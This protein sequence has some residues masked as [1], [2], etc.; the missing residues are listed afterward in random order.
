MQHNIPYPDIEGSTVV[1][2]HNTHELVSLTG[3]KDNKKNSFHR[4]FQSFRQPGSAIKHLLVYGPYIDRNNAAIDEQIDS[5]AFCK[6]GYC[7]RNYGNGNYGNV[8]L[9]TAF[10]KS[11]NTSAV[12]IFD[13][14]G[15]N[16][17]FAYLEKFKFTK[18][19]KDDYQLPAAIGGFTYGM[20]PIEITNAY[21]SFNNGS[22]QTARAIRKI[23]DS[24]GKTL[25]QWKEHPI[26]IWNSNTVVKMKT[27]LHAVIKEGTA[28]KADYI[29]SSN[30][31]GK[32]GT[33]NDYKDLWMIGY[34]DQY[35]TG[36][37]IGK[38]HPENIE[39][40]GSPHLFI[41]RN[42]MQF[43]ANKPYQK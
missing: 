26:Q 43:T 35:T 23:T 8:K 41:W 34:N 9:K 3:A 22:Y 18:L 42:I 4:G 37:W 24:S 19:M 30:I 36:V 17:S 5:S 12:R 28:K 25:Y 1:I 6:N 40:S 2:Q 10:A 27:L 31:G 29:T 20:S 39:Y 16:N 7:P 21:T 11:Y 15:I 13:Q 33:T 38:D 14:I 32:T